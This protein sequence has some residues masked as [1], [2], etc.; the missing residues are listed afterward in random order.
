[1]K[2]LL[3]N[4]RGYMSEAKDS[5]KVAKVVVIRDDK[6]LILLRADSEAHPGKWD[7]PGGHIHVGVDVKEGLLREVHEETELELREPIK[8]I[9]AEGRAT[10]F[11][12]A[13]PQ[14]EIKLSH[15]HTEHRFISV[16]EIPEN[17][18]DKFVRAIK[19]AL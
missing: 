16:D 3:E 12:A 8:Q 18:S 2:L 7:L 4:W 1:M 5:D 17:I 9:Y 19:K 15:E 14:Q 11:K 13:M 10:F 6:A